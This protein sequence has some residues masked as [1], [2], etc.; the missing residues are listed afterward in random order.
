MKKIIFK[1]LFLAI[2]SLSLVIPSSS[3]VADSIPDEQFSLGT[4]LSA[5]SGAELQGL[6]IR[7]DSENTNMPSVLIASMDTARTRSNTYLI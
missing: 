4:T 1:K 6:F 2:L 7:E 3:V 5:N